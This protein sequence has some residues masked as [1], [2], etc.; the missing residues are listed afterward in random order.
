MCEVVIHETRKQVRI[1]EVV[2]GFWD[3]ELEFIPLSDGMSNRWGVAGHK[4]GCT[5]SKFQNFG[6]RRGGK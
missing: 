5:G 1:R 3:I 2:M 6:R 4:D